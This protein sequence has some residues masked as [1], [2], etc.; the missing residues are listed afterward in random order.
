MVSCGPPRAVWRLPSETRHVLTVESRSTLAGHSALAT[1]NNHLRENAK[2]DAISPFL[3][4]MV[5]EDL[6]S[7]SASASQSRTERAPPTARVAPSGENASD[8]MLLCHAATIL[9]H[10]PSLMSH[11]RTSRSPTSPAG[12]MDP[13][14]SGDPE[15]ENAI[16][17]VAPIQSSKILQLWPGS[18]HKQIDWSVLPDASISPSGEKQTHWAAQQCNFR[19]AHSRVGPSHRQNHRQDIHRPMKMPLS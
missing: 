1:R 9:A 8:Q 14:A 11:R 4:M 19:F 5:V 16:E 17:V 2:E 6:L 12:F 15:G 3:S 7:P 13:E 10:L 18:F